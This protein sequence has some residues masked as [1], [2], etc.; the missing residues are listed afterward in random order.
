MP[1][2]LKNTWQQPNPFTILSMTAAEIAGIGTPVE[3]MI[4]YDTT[5]DKFAVYQAS[6]WKLL[7]VTVP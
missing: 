5:N 7:Q 1:M 3:G 6:A 2:D 4:V